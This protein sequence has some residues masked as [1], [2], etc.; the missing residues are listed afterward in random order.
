MSPDGETVVSGG[1]DGTVRLWP[2]WLAEQGWVNY[3][4]NRI[5]GYFVASSKTDEMVRAARRTCERSV[6]R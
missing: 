4:C 2:L 3:T 6:W 5:R 1:D